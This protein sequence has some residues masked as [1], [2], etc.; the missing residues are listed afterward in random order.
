MLPYGGEISFRDFNTDRSLPGSQTI[1]MTNAAAA[2]GV[3]YGVDGSNHLSMDEFWGGQVI[4]NTYTGCG[5]G[6]TFGEVCGDVFTGNR[7]FY[8]NI[9]P[10]DF[11]EGAYVYVDQYPNVLIGYDY[12]Y[13]NGAVWRI[14]NAQGYIIE[15]AADFQC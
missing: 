10:F 12:V 7:T 11:A 5:R 15:Y 14:D 2:Y 13:I 9:G 8:S 1:T 6:N 4:F 3:S